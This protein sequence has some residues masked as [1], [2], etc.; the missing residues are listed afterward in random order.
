MPNPRLGPEIANHFE[1]GYRGSIGSPE[2]IAFTLNT[3]LYYSVINGKIVT[4]EW[5]RP[6]YPSSTTNVARNLDS[7]AFWGF[8][9]APEFTWNSYL[10]TG[11][12]F[13]WNQYTIT[14]SQLGVNV[15]TY[16]PEFT[17]NGYV[18]IKSVKMLS[19]IPRVEYTG[20]RYA[21]SEGKYPL[22]GY[23]LAHLKVGAD[24]G[25]HFTVSIGVENILDTYYEIRQHSPMAGRSFN[26]SFTARY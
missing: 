22:D 9:L 10:N 4:V 20:S 11:L 18:V 7:T 5:P 25:S 24:L 26:V 14:H 19:I 1:L 21:D 8:E 17:L 12:A 15:L 2:N 3:A 23:F 6:D 13:S 16:Y